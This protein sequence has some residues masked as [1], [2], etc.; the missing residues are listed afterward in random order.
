VLAPTAWRLLWRWRLTEGKGGK[1][2]SGRKL[3]AGEAGEGTK[4]PCAAHRIDQPSPNFGRSAERP[5]LTGVI[6]LRPAL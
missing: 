1:D 2:S 3:V 5:S 4:T 6:V